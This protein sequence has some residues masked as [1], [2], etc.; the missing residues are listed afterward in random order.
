MVKSWRDG[1]RSLVMCCNKALLWWSEFLVD[2]L[3]TIIQLLVQKNVDK[4][5]SLSSLVSL[6]IVYQ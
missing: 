1:D 5:Y 4:S 2:Q 6:M 3:I